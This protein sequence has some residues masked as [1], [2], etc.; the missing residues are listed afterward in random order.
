MKQPAFRTGVGNDQQDKEIAMR[1]EIQHEL[2]IA[3]DNDGVSGGSR[4]TRLGR[5]G[6]PKR[7]T[8]DEE[9]V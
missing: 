1:R 6:F 8:H 7:H 3:G 5:E 2:S 4:R 9:G